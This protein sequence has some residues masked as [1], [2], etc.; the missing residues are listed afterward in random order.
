MAAASPLC[1]ALTGATGYVGRHVLPQLLIAGHRVRA[2]VRDPAKLTITD[3]KVHAVKGDLFDP[4]AL[5]QLV[6][7]AD[8]VVHLVG[9]IMER[10]GRGQTFERVHTLGTRSLVAAA[11]RAGVKRWV[12][13]SAVGAR[14]NGVSQYHR[15]KWAAECA[16]RDSG[17]DFTVFRPSVIHGPDGEFMQLVKGFCCNAFPPF[18]PYFGAGLL[19]RGGAGRLQP[20]WVEDV[21]RCFAQALT[22][23][24]SIGETYPMGGP[25]TYTWPQFYLTC[26]RHIPG[27]KTGRKP[28]AVP[29]WYAK[30]IAGMPGVPFNRD[31]VIMSQE[32]SVCQTAKAEAHFGFELAQLEPALARYA[33]QIG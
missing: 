25:D 3:A 19:G 8:A 6:D 2:L 15:T 10:P 26:Q 32:D 22:L 1:V 4:V 18:M 27:A 12:H 5:D 23:P 21:A 13:M 9:I 33:D 16:V 11:K 29:A 20:V 28:L 30:A 7:G 14:P 24:R 31:Q 17:L